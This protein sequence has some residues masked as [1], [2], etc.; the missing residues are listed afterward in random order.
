MAKKTE[1]NEQNAVQKAQDKIK[2][3]NDQKK[4]DLDFVTWKM[5][6]AQI[7]K[8][9]A[10]DAL[11]E[12]TANTNLEAYEKAEQ[13]KKA[14]LTAMEMYSKRYEQLENREFISEIE[15]D[16]VIDEILSYENALEG[17]FKKALENELDVLS[18]LLST[19]R[20][21]VER[22]EQTLNTWTTEIHANYRT[23]GRTH[24]IDP[25]TGMTTDRS[26]YPVPVHTTPYRG[27]KEAVQLS[28]YM[29]IA[30]PHYN[31]I[32]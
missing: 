2:E 10:E 27:C 8:D 15:S 18:S 32:W 29:D 3:L 31:Y 16:R 25:E 6:E 23:W 7:Q 11:R 30:R 19:Y 5:K 9:A 28:N 26:S 20:N 17:E 1:P 4:T 24:N 14:A 13:E 22:A 21:A 12:A